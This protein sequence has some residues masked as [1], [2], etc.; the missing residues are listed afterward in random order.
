MT[1]VAFFYCVGTSWAIN[2]FPQ[3][4]NRQPLLRSAPGT[5]SA[6]VAGINGATARWDGGPP[7]DPFPSLLDPNIFEARTVP[8]L[9]AALPIGPSI[10][11]GIARVVAAVN[12]LPSG[13]PFCLGGY[14]QGAIV[15]TGAARQGLLPGT[16]GALSGRASSF[17]GATMFGNPRRANNH[18]GVGGLGTTQNWTGGSGSHGSFPTTGPYARLS[19]APDNWAEYTHQY[20]ILTSVGD[21]TLANNWVQANDVFV[22][23]NP[24][25]FFINFLNYAVLDA[26]NQALTVAGQAL[27]QRDATGTNFSWLTGNGHTSYPFN[28]YG[29]YGLTAYQAALTYLTGL[30][31]QYVVGPILGPING[32]G[33][34]VTAGWST[35]LTAPS[36]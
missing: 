17:L 10:D 18:I 20:D 2:L 33:S 31:Q 30:A 23:G 29:Q 22:T 21:N 32:G 15:M 28:A 35:T 11:D 36:A 16:S 26:V 34:P 6:T 9:A 25:T 5:N 8:Y 14:S 7:G 12:A 1:K 24:F 4:L 3:G 19:S 13:Q 27:N